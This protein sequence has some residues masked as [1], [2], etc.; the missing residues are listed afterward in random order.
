[1]FETMHL[2]THTLEYNFGACRVGN[3]FDDGSNLSGVQG[4]GRE[5]NIELC[6]K[7][8]E[9][10]DVELTGL[11]GIIKTGDSAIADGE[12]TNCITERMVRWM[13]TRWSPNTVIRLVEL[14]MGG[15]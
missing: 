10:C 2:K 3:L 5:K 13:L 11:I 6:W 9:R 14:P 12:R 4:W 8:P 1:M 15:N 7:Q